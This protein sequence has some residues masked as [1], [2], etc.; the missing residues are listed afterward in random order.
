MTT[1]TKPKLLIIEDDPGL[2]VLAD[3]ERLER[4]VGHL[5]QNAIEATARDGRVEIALS[6]RN[7][8]VRIRISDTGAGM[9]EEFLRERL[10]KPFEST[11]SAGM[12]IGVFESQEYIQELRGKLEVTS[13]PGQGSTFTI[14][15]PLLNQEVQTINQAA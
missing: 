15:L 6:R 5:I 12:G 10:F 1:E 13:V 11:K 14:S 3:D 2:T 7:D 4:V 9:S 8:T